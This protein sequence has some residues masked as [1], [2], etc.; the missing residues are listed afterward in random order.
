M[1][2]CDNFFCLWLKVAS[3]DFQYRL[4]GQEDADLLFVK[5]EYANMLKSTC[6]HTHI[7]KITSKYVHFFI[8]I[9]CFCV[10]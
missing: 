9:K 4:N 7:C 2:V 5:G 8:F 3:M 10:L 1:F 6:T